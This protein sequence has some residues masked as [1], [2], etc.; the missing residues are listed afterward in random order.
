MDD[1]EASP[2]SSSM[3]S[4]AKVER[5]SVV[6]AVTGTVADV[7]ACI[8]GFAPEGTVPAA[9]DGEGVYVSLVVAADDG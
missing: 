6:R 4:K 5:G 2:I 7:R 8:I 1:E 3:I 9:T